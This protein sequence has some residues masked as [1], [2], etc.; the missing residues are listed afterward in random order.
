MILTGRKAPAALLLALAATTTACG[1]ATGAGVATAGG[2]NATP[3][4]SASASKDPRDA[5]VEFAQCLRDHGMQVA[6][7]DEKGTVVLGGDE[8]DEQKMREAHE[9]CKDKAP[10]VGVGPGGGLDATALEQMLKF[11]RC[12]REHGIDMPDPGADGGVRMD[13]GKG[14]VDPESE[15]FQAAQEACKQYFA[16]GA[17]GVGGASGP[18]STS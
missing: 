7:P 14:G 13:V 8:A 12:M 4:A 9:A 17:G 2:G 11:S 6:D 10:P 18:G 3:T 1:S 16:P 15:E 5:A